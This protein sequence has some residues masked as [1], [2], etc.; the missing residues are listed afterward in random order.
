LLAE[1]PLI[2]K[3][4][5]VTALPVAA[6]EVQKVQY[7]VGG[8]VALG[9]GG[10]VAGLVVIGRVAHAVTCA[11]DLLH[12][13]GGRAVKV[14]KVIAAL[15][16]AEPAIVRVRAIKGLLASDLLI[17]AACRTGDSHKG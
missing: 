4:L 5:N 12:N 10:V 7:T 15:F 9:S 17:V 6:L 2:R 1:I 16:P 14:G 11:G 8:T 3:S 13:T